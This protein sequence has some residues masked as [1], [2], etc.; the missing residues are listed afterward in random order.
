MFWTKTVNQKKLCF[1][2]WVMGSPIG[3]YGFPWSSVQ[4]FELSHTLRESMDLKVLNDRTRF[5][6]VPFNKLRNQKIPFDGKSDHIPLMLMA[7]L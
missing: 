7:Y 2:E 1:Y 5:N 6:Y 4:C 3:F